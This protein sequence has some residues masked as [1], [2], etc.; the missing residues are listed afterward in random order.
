MPTELV[1]RTL[2]LQAAAAAVTDRQYRRHHPVRQG[3]PASEV[4]VEALGQQ[5]REIDRSQVVVAQQAAHLIASRKQSLPEIGC[6]QWPA[7][8]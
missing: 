7:R 3:H 8:G 6:L 1:G 4:G 2:A 5:D